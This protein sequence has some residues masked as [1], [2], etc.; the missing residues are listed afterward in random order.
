MRAVIHQES[1]GCWR[2]ELRD[3]RGHV[4]AQCPRHYDH[5]CEVIEEIRRLRCQAV[6]MGVFDERGNNIPLF[7][8]RA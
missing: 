6:D 7:P 4:L 3:S 1:T 5:R 2:W 8:G